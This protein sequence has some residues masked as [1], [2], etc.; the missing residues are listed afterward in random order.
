MNYL[1]HYN[2]LLYFEIFGFITFALAFFDAWRQQEKYYRYEIISAV[3]FG[4]LLEIVN[5]YFAQ[6]YFY[7]Q[8]FLLQ[9]YGVPLVIAC[10]WALIIYAVMRLSDQY[11]IPWKFKPFIDA[12]TV[13]FLDL[14][15]D[16]VASGLSFWQWRIPSTQ[17]WFGVP[18]ENFFGWMM[19]VLVFSFIMRWLRRLDEQK[20]SWRYLKFFSP[21]MAYIALAITL[22]VYWLGVVLTSRNTLNL[23]FPPNTEIL[24]NPQIQFWKLIFL[25]FTIFLFLIIT[26]TSRSNLKQ[27]KQ[28]KYVLFPQIV[29]SGIYL[30]FTLIIFMEDLS[31]LESGFIYIVILLFILHHTLHFI[32]SSRKIFPL[33][34]PADV[35]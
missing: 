32:L 24:S 25:L 6:A 3:F 8:D 26:I 19:V 1:P 22:S 13:L 31:I 17:E 28:L 30:F 4:L 2:W 23:V 16:P 10:G 5:I 14:V 11:A 27:K 18:Y 34:I 33:T 7:H 15:I 12:L 20:S 35:N 29:I 9:I 21:I